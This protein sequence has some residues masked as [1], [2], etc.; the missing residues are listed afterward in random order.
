MPH[1]VREQVREDAVECLHVD[2][3]PQFARNLD[4]DLL[5]I[6]VDDDLDDLLQVLA[7]VDLGGGDEQ[8]VGLETRE[9]E[10]VLD[11]LEEPLRLL[12]QHLAQLG[13][14][15]RR[16]LARAL[17]ERLHG[18]VDR[19]HRGAQLVRRE[20]GELALQLIQAT[21]L[22]VLDR[23]LEKGGDQRAEGRQEVDLGR[24]ER[25]GLAALVAR[26]ESETAAVAD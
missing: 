1:R 4:R 26:Q 22:A 24:V 2:R 6:A 15:L 20:R 5:E 18:A 21:E 25:E 23:P 14:A 7:H 11:E 19:R 16:K 10:E 13:L 17:L 12:G 9:V 8:R 3:R